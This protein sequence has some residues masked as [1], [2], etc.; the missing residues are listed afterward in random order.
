[1]R[2]T[3]I[4]RCFAIGDCKFHTRNNDMKKMQITRIFSCNLLAVLL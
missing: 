3:D 1:M 4:F 2:S